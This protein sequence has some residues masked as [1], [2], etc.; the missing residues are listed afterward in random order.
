MTNGP[1]FTPWAFIKLRVLSAY[2]TKRRA[3]Y[4]KQPHRPT[5]PDTSSGIAAILA[6]YMHL[7]KGYKKPFENQYQPIAKSSND[8]GIGL[9]R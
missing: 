8:I 1:F 3:G 4:Y 5:E 7:I 6:V 9:L 2:A